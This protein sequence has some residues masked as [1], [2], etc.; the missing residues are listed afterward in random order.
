MD[1]RDMY[2]LFRREPEAK[3]FF[4]A[5]PDYVQDQLRIRPNGIKNLEGLKDYAHRS[6]HGERV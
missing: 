2:A 6:L 5:L 4:D 3:R 1:Y